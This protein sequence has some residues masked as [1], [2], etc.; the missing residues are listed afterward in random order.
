ML[1]RALAAVRGLADRLDLT[2]DNSELLHDGS[3]VLVRVGS[4]VAKVATTTAS[5]RPDAAAWQ[6]RDVTL[7]RFAGARGVPVVRPCDVPPAGPHHQDGFAIT[8]W[9]HTAHDQGGVT[10]P[11]EVGVLLG[12]LHAS[13]ADYGGA[14]PDDGPMR[15][16]DDILGML[17][18]TDAPADVLSALRERAPLSMTRA[19]RAAADWPVQALH[20]DAH[21]G[22][23][24]VT[25]DGPR[26]IDFED[27]WRGPIAWDLAV[28]ARTSR[29]DGRAA[30]AAYPGAPPIASIEPFVRLRRLHVACW[31]LI[32]AR[33]FPDRRDAARADVEAYLSAP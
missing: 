26:W 29:L 12:R 7:A 13:L 30:V 20:G 2:A 8:L 11:E 15:E 17:D 3:N 9:P 22:N 24:L 14:L 18:P 10:G 1:E 32:L 19:D 5:V 16:I 27:A 4:V 25:V 23:L 6:E 21:P 31:H 28:L 33:R